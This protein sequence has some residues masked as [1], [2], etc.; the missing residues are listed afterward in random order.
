MKRHIALLVALLLVAATLPAYAA[1]AIETTEETWYVLSHSDDYRVYFYAGVKN[2]SDKPVS[3]NDLLFEIQAPDGLT[4]D[5][6]AKY[7]L[8]PE[9][10]KAGEEGWLVI[11]KDVKD[12]ASKSDIDHYTLT[13]T[14]KVNEDKECVALAANAGYLT[15]DEDDN[16]DVLRASVTNSNSDVAFDITVAM[17]AKDAEGKLLYVVGDTAKD[18]GL[19]ANAALLRRSLIRTDIMDELED[20]GVEIASAAAIAYTVNDLDD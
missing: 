18:T 16:E 5:S 20:N 13:I 14:S 10:L 6:T 3:V 15:K 4:I 19:A 7:K 9:V 8:Y 11:S 17:A 1:G 12:V 2:G